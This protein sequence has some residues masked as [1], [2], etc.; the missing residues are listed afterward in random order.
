MRSTER[1]EGSI[2]QVPGKDENQGVSQKI[3]AQKIERR[4]RS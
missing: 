2:G 1:D 3:E 4:P